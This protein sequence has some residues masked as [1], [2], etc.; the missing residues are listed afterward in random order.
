MNSWK[1][2]IASS[3]ASGST[4]WKFLRNRTSVAAQSAVV[5]GSSIVAGSPSSSTYSRV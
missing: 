3:H 5:I 2:I 1:G 4:R